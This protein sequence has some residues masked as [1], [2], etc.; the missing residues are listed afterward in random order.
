MFSLTIVTV[1]L[2]F[3]PIV[4]NYKLYTLIEL[5]IKENNNFFLQIKAGLCFSYCRA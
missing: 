5:K 3:F 1:V 2:V 4:I